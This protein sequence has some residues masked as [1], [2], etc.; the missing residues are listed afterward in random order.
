MKGFCRLTRVIAL[1]RIT[2]VSRLK[3]VTHAPTCT[4]RAQYS[5]FCELG[6]IAMRGCATHARASWGETSEKMGFGEKN[7][8]VKK[9]PSGAYPLGTPAPEVPSNY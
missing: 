8:G 1:S 6:K 9:I 2:P 3:H 5:T 4:F 7:A